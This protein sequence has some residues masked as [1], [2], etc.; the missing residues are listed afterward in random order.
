MK[1]IRPSAAAYYRKKA[2]DIEELAEQSKH[3]EVRRD[4][5]EVAER[6][7]RLADHVERLRRCGSLVHPTSYFQH[8][9][10]PSEV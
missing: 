7:R 9:E 6:F 4:L 2:E 5:L 1:S 10:E 3:T 8:Q